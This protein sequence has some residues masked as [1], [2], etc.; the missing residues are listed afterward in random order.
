MPFHAFNLLLVGILSKAVQRDRCGVFFRS[1]T[2]L[3]Q[4]RLPSCFAGSCPMQ[5]TSLPQTFLRVC[6]IIG[7]VVDIAATKKAG[8]KPEQGLTI[9]DAIT[10]GSV[11]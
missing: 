2:I 7:P 4:A 5:Y 6:Q 10:V 3:S 9:Y 1:L 8:E 11:T